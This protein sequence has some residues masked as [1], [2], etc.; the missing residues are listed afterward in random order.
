PAEIAAVVIGRLIEADH[1]SLVAAV[2]V[3][4]NEGRG[5]SGDDGT[6]FRRRQAVDRRQA[7]FVD[8]R[9]NGQV[10]GLVR[11]Y[12][13]GCNGRVRAVGKKPQT[14]ASWIPSGGGNRSG[15]FGGDVL[16][17]LTNA[18]RP[19]IRKQC[20]GSRMVRPPPIM[21]A[22][23]ATAQRHHRRAIVP[24][25]CRPSLFSVAVSVRLVDVVGSARRCVL[26]LEVYG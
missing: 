26:H 19:L 20:G 21:T 18:L 6:K 11:A 1:E 3:K 8:G 7:R 15:V 24:N 2:A 17:M 16:P 23:A 10:V 5:R 12:D 9:Q 22:H 4:R 14:K 25:A 13:H